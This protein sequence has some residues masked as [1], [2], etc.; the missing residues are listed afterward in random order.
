MRPRA[1]IACVA[2]L[3][4]AGCGTSSTGSRTE[5]KQEKTMD[6][7]QAAEHADRILDDTFAAI[8][9][10]VRW[11][12]DETISGGCP[13]SPGL[14]DVSR[15]RTVM[16]IIS[17][18][19]R[20]NFLGLVER[21]WKKKGYTITGTNP[22]KEFPAL[23]ASAPGDYRMELVFGAKGQAFFSVA[24]PCFAKSEVPEP[25][26]TPNGPNYAGKEVPYPDQKSDFWSSTE[27]LTR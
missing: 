10:P 26:S 9:P 25:K 2:I 11:T 7:R 1:V 23:F 24:T 16:T 3:A 20:G 6:M 8:V 19:R 13:G 5:R 4:L 12:H 22:D 15:H 17:E 14:G 18:Q 27:P 21:H